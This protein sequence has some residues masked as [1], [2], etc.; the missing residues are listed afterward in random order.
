ME[1][2]KEFGEDV[3]TIAASKRVLE[4]QVR[5]QQILNGVR[6]ESDEPLSL[7]DAEYLCSFHIDNKDRFNQQD[8]EQIKK[9][10]L[11]LFANVEPKNEHNNHALKEINTQDNPV[12]RIKAQTKK[13]NN[14]SRTRNKPHYEN[15]RTPAMVN[16]ARNCQVQLTGTNLCPKWGLYHG[17]SGTVLDIVYLPTHSPP[18]SLPLYVL[19]DF[20]QYCGPPFIKAAPTIVPIAPIK[21]Q[22]KFNCCCRTYMPLRLAFA[23]TI[24]TFQ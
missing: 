24:H 15:E 19:V 17:A 5:L 8:K 21:V 22:C 4:G 3:M 6:G 13:L 11:Y 18:D 10:A 23:Q 1:L 2:F 12:A 14:G 16:I 7:E 9:D 20:P